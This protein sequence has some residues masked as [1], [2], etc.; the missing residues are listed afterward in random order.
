MSK[1][2]KSTERER[3]IR[4]KLCYIYTK[5]PAKFSPNENYHPVIFSRRRSWGIGGK[6]ERERGSGVGGARLGKKSNF[7]K[8]SSPRQHEKGIAENL[9]LALFRRFSLFVRFWFALFIPRP[10]RSGIIVS[11]AVVLLLL[12]SL[13]RKF[14]FPRYP[15]RFFFLVH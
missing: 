6:R 2:A 3:K 10:R 1:Q 15:C 13:F 8:V 11:V 12:L 4:S 14:V 5:P 9:V 7:R